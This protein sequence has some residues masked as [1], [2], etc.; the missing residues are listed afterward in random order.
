MLVKAYAG[1]GQ[2]QMR[3]RAMSQPPLMLGRTATIKHDEVPRNAVPLR[4]HANLTVS[5]SASL[6]AA[7]KKP[8]TASISYAGIN[9]STLYSDVAW[10]TNGS[11]RPL[12][13]ASNSNSRQSQQVST[14]Q[15]APAAYKRIEGSM[16]IEPPYGNAGSMYWPYNER[17]LSV[18]NVNSTASSSRTAVQPML[19]K[20]GQGPVVSEMPFAAATVPS[21]STPTR[22]YPDAYRIADTL[23][24][25]EQLTL[26]DASR[27]FQH[28]NSEP[29]VPLSAVRIS[30]VKGDINESQSFQP[31]SP[32][33]PI[34]WQGNGMLVESSQTGSVAREAP[35]A[36]LLSVRRVSESVQQ[37]HN[38]W[39]GNGNVPHAAST[40]GQTGGRALSRHESLMKR[41]D[42]P[43]VTYG[44]PMSNLFR[45]QL[46]GPSG[47]APQYNT[48]TQVNR[49]PNNVIPMRQQANVNGERQL[50]TQ[51]PRQANVQQLQLTNR[52]PYT[53][54]NDNLAR[55]HS[56]REPVRAPTQQQPTY[57]T[58]ESTLPSRSAFV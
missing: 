50:Q 54:N 36:Q 46:Q 42:R 35:S 8:L 57:A 4:G 40:R 3:G 49:N 22:G 34:G 38:Y 37:S 15:N 55:V 52:L 21:V 32:G 11:Y 26:P 48:H 31:Q 18:P 53:Q 19:S 44:Q 28:L 51:Y 12:D 1:D 24:H 41:N 58:T 23:S 47:A 27:D 16:I 10:G 56:I 14:P 39:N 45:S 9:S 29:M 33:L 7:A 5:S 43:D 6:E 17:K 25:A 30:R 13:H 2:D 20:T